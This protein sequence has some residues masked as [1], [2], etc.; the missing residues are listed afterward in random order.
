MEP[1]TG[2]LLSGGFRARVRMLLGLELMVTNNHAKA[3][4]NTIVF[5]TL[6][7]VKVDDIT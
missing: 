2:P 5:D 3:W 1:S 6:I 4:F 7:N